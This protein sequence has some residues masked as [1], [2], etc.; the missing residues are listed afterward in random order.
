MVISLFIIGLVGQTKIIGCPAEM[1]IVLP[2]SETYTTEIK[3]TNLLLHGPLQLYFSEN[4][5][6]S[7][8]R[9]IDIIRL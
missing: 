9:S 1:I 2:S 3:S 8:R 7:V 4:T 6:V 5:T